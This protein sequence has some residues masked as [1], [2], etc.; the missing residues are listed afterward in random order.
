[1]P[2]AGPAQ[3]LLLQEPAEAAQHL[4]NLAV[5]RSR[6]Q[7][8]SKAGDVATVIARMREVVAAF[9]AHSESWNDLGAL[10][11]MSGQLAE[12]EC[13][14][15]KAFL[16]DTKNFSALGNLVE[17][18]IR[19]NKRQ[20]AT[21]LVEQWTRL[22]PH[23]TRAWVAWAKL[24]RLAANATSPK[25][26]RTAVAGTRVGDSAIPNA[27][28]LLRANAAKR[29]ASNRRPAK[30]DKS[31]EKF[32][33][34]T[35]NV[36]DVLTENARQSFKAAAERWRAEYVELTAQ[37]DA[38]APRPET[39]ATAVAAKFEKFELFDRCQ[40]DRIFYID[41]A[42]AIVRSDAPTPFEICPPD[43]VGAVLNTA[44]AGILYRERII[45][46]QQELEWRLFNSLQ[47][48]ERACPDYFNTGVL[49]LT[50][51]SHAGMLQRAR[52]LREALVSAGLATLWIDQ[53]PLNYA[54][55][56]LGIP[57]CLM[58][59]TWNY[60]CPENFGHWRHMER[61]VYHFAG[62][63]GLRG[64]LHSLNW[65]APAGARISVTV[66]SSSL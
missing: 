21:A 48:R 54:A 29:A 32:A 27:A 19:S 39:G 50:R 30:G 8:A 7:G 56:E 61:L 35:I 1:M 2:S 23:S 65:Q 10:L 11:G 49:V 57:I 15:Q 36:G 66:A 33:V 13:C 59:E 45:A 47:G 12:A 22:Q 20:Q 55:A 53:T 46:C 40:A 4:S 14:F 64:I 63:F 18:L 16:A 62:S 28:D 44:P 3:E 43:E 17:V 26:A 60:M 5:L 24:D 6:A 31:P 42:D 38:P 9:P 34:M 25:T 51:A 52:Q 37:P 41:G 58:D